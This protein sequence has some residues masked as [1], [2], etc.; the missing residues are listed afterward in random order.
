VVGQIITIGVENE[1]LAPYF[2]AL[3]RIAGGAAKVMNF[4]I[5][6]LIP[7]NLSTYRY[8]GS[9]TA[10]PASDEELEEF[11]G[12]VAWNIFAQGITVSN[13]QFETF[14]RLFEGGNARPL[15]EQ[16]TPEVFTDVAPIPLPS[17]GVLFLFALGGLVALRRRAA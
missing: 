16:S 11:L 9:L 5:A 12:P 4:N 1:A 15:Q 6:A 7:E 10:P 8:T 14:R 3:S 17:S 13:E 2:D